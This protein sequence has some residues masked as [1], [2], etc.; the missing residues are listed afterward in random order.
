MRECA[1]STHEEGKE[2]DLSLQWMVIWEETNTIYCSGNNNKTGP[3]SLYS[4]AK[5]LDLLPGCKTHLGSKILVQRISTQANQPKMC[6]R[7]SYSEEPCRQSISNNVDA[8]LWK[9]IVKA[10]RALIAV[11]NTDGISDAGGNQQD[12]TCYPKRKRKEISKQTKEFF[13]LSF[14]SAN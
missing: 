4:T 14:P 9:T 5:P 1:T 11:C 8:P 7:H 12:Y 2:T 13:Q 6:G 3:R 10:L